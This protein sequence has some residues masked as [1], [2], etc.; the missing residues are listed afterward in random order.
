[1]QEE[2]RRIHDALSAAREILRGYTSGAV[3]HRSKA[4]G[5]PVTEADLAVD[6]ALR[7]RLPRAGEG[8]LSEETVDDRSRLGRERVEGQ[9]VGDLGHASQD[10]PRT[11]RRRL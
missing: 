11:R 5:S 1:M 8:W 9:P 2:L 10:T 4:G 7:E 3:D 6:R